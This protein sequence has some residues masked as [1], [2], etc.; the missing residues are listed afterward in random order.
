MDATHEEVLKVWS[1][2]CSRFGEASVLLIDGGDDMT[3]GAA[4]T[5]DGDDQF[6]DMIGDIMAEMVV[7]GTFDTFHRK[8]RWSAV[9]VPSF[10]AYM[11]EG[12][13]EPN[14][15]DL[16]QRYV[17]GDEK[18]SEVV[19]VVIATMDG[20]PT[21]MSYRQ[22]LLEPVDDEPSA[23]SGGPITTGVQAALLMAYEYT[24]TG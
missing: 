1:R 3:I 14:H 6:T 9:A 2:T 21:G 8:P 23:M 5:P 20:R 7:A 12:L 19:L 13:P 10:S 17:E 22:P 16:Q 24:A 11:N 18:V 4:F 15:G